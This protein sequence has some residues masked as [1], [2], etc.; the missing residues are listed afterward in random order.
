MAIQKTKEPSKVDAA[1]Q[2]FAEMLIKRMEEM[3]KDWHKGWIGGGS[4]FGLPQNISGRTYEGSNAFLL[5]LH[6]AGNGYKAPVYMTYGQIHKEGALVHKGEKAVPVFKWGFSIKDKD[7]KKVTEEEFN[8]MTDDEKKECKRRPF[9]RIYPEFN[10]DQ[11]NMS[12]VNKEKYDAVVSQFRKTDA[13]TITDGM[14]VNK[15]IDRMMENQEWV[16]KIQY[17]KE[18]QG[19][20]YSP[21]KDIVVLPTK[22]QFRIHPDDPEEC[23]KD[24]QEYY[25]TALH[26]MAHSTGHPSR[27]DRLKPAAFGSPEY[28]KEELVAELTSAMV[29][30]TLGFDR[31]I[32]DNNVAYLQNWT[33]ALR[34]EP[35][36]IVS[37]MADVNKASRIIIENI[38]KQRV[39]LGEKPLVQG[40]LDGVEEKVK[41]EQQFEEIKAEEKKEDPREA[42]VKEWDSLAEKPI[43]ELPSGDVLPVEYNKEKDTL[44]VLITNETGKQELYSTNYD[45]DRNI[46]E[47]VG[48]VWEELSNLQQYR[49]QEPKKE[50]KIPSLRE[51]G[52]Y[53]VLEG[54]ISAAEDDEN[55]PLHKV[56]NFQD[57]KKTFA[58]VTDVN[59]LKPVYANTDDEKMALLKTQVAA[60]SQKE[61]LELGA[62]K[63]PYYHYSHKEGRTLYDIRK[64]FERIE[65]IGKA[66]PDNEQIQK[67]VEQARSIFNRYEHNVTDDFSMGEIFED[68]DEIE[69]SPIP[70]YTYIEGL[71]PLEARQ[72]NQKEFDSLEND[73]KAIKLKTGEVLPVRYNIDNNML[74]AGREVDGN[75][76]VVLSRKY[77][78]RM[79]GI[80]NMEEFALKSAKEDAEPEQVSSEDVTLSGKKYF[81]TLINSIT[82]GQHDDHTALGI[83]NISEL[84]DYFKDNSHVNEWMEGAS[85]RELIEAGAD[86]L[87]NIRYPHKEGRTLYDMTA[88]YSNINAKYEDVSDDRTR[89][90]AHRIDQAKSIITAYQTNIENAHD[91]NYL[92][93]EESAHKIIPREEYAKSVTQEQNVEPTQEKMDEIYYFSHTYLQ[94]TD[95]C[96]EFDNLVEKQD[97][98]S[99][100]YLTREY[101]QGDALLQSQTYKNAKKSSGDDILAEDDNYIVVY[102]N[103]VGGTYDLMRKVTKQDIIDSI[104]RYGLESDASDDVKKVAYEDVAKQFSDIKSKIPAFTMPNEDVLYYQYNQE[105]NKIEVGTKTDEGL[106]VAQTFDY[107]VDRTLDDNLDNVYEQLSELPEYQKTGEQKNAVAHEDSNVQTNVE[108][109]AEDIAETGVPM[110]QAEKEAKTIVDDKQHEEFHE[111]EDK[112][113]EHD[114]AKAEKAQADK[115]KQQQESKK[116]EDKPSKGVA[117]AAILLGALAAAKANDGVWMNKESKSNAEFIFAHTPVTA[118]NNIMM[119]LQSDQKGYRTNVFTSFNNAQKNGVAV[120][121]G[122]KATPFNWTQWDYQ[123]LTDKNDIISQKE[124]EKLSDEEKKMYGKHASRLT[125]YIYNID[126]TTYPA[127]GGDQFVTLLKE[128]G[129]QQ[130]SMKP[131]TSA[132]FLKQFDEIKAKHPDVIVIMRK[133]DSYEIYK[134]D[135]KKAAEATHLPVTKQE[136]EGKM[137]DTVS[138]SHTMLD[139]HLPNI[140]RAGH[141][142]AVCDQLEDPKLVKS[143][144]EGKV[145]LDRA[146]STAKAVAKQEGIKYERVMVI[147]DAKYDKTD[148]KIE[149]SGMIDKS[150]GSERLAA[151]QK[152]NDIYRAVVAATG[153]ENRLDRSGRNS[154]LPE[155]DA[156]HEKLVQE[157]AAGVLM[158]RQGLPATL[159]KESQKLIPYWERELKENPKM[160]GVIE[161]DV[162]NAVETIDN[163]LA[164]REVNYKAIRGQLPPKMI[165]DKA[166][167]YSLAADLA[168]LPSIDTKEVVVIRDKKANKVDVILPAGA[169]VEANNEVP[170]MRKDRISIALKKEGFNEV[171]FYNA[172]GSLGLNKPNT[173]FEGKDVSLNQLKQYQLLNHKTIDVAQQPKQEN[174]VEIEHFRAIKDDYGRWAFYIKPK[175]EPQF[176]VYPPKE[177][178]NKYFSVRNT[179]DEKTTRA[180]LA[181][182]W[183]E[184]AKQFPEVRVDIVNPHPAKDIDMSRIVNPTITKSAQDP[185]VK[186]VFA[187]IDGERH[188]ATVNETQWQ[189]M[190]L[191]DNMAEYKKAVAAVVFE[192]VLRKGMESQQTQSEVVKETEKVD[193]KEAPEPEPK[194]EEHEKQSTSRGV[195]M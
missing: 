149:V 154:L 93:E 56:S 144:P 94:S 166:E 155:D 25:G 112:K 54:I 36:F 50:E 86:K 44:D 29:G 62:Y 89:Q 97:Y 190:W 46:E 117:H 161:R 3:Q 123:N 182:K 42:V 186:L 99:L 8:N 151:L 26:E 72:Q 137:I 135:A 33:S 126:Q 156:K 152:A 88:A 153:T 5:F 73:M 191:A 141:R 185:K 100:L 19:A 174:K 70:R 115:E 162:N 170:G 193:V 24:G 165:T 14:Y 114:Q 178:M 43:V 124:Y 67:R 119:N 195:H 171:K 118:Y 160:V 45:H 169:S 110:E 183:Y 103:S 102:N 6:T 76:E 22:A 157:L 4:M 147:Q 52:N 41:N 104:Q 63:L 107:D 87:P 121:Q 82:D 30:N 84:R 79:E 143:V 32:S 49:E 158:A 142:V 74:E 189:R 192:P 95:S 51:S 175:N 109:L 61:L 106:K 16:C 1:L 146:Y 167:N 133:D 136:I 148:D 132:S 194:Q 101:D 139:V 173:Y 138:F 81:S 27:L 37:V 140:I 113:Q 2:R 12:E 38:D 122:E 21:A 179:P 69:S 10:I 59:K 184:V 125:Q 98:D 145:V 65:N 129:A 164:K 80:S 17:D 127:V 48:H 177:H 68:G 20:Y 108:G 85:N 75:F 83:K 181:N 55:H 23:F 150:V 159:S 172:G 90:I 58:S 11:T 131:S 134:S 28:A 53:M 35:K 176:S 18:E 31:R 111:A 92:F 78:R 96:E 47:N 163:L 39:A 40:A 71:L 13:P 66:N 188:H 187:T 168:K 64:S 60:M 9:L 120:K 130:E 91:E 77:D 128:K 116:D 7:G 180:V 34:K 15:A 57:F 105:S